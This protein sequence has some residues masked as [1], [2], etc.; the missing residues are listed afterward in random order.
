MD[1]STD[2][3]LEIVLPGMTEW[4]VKEVA[5]DAG[6]LIGFEVVRTQQATMAVPGSEDQSE[7][8]RVRAELKALADALN[9]KA[10]PLVLP[11]KAER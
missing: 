6:D 10:E 8:V 11:G 9:R 3:Y 4:Q 1:R 5:N 7:L 2:A